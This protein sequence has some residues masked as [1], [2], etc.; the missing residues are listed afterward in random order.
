MNCEMVMHNHDL[1]RYIFAWL[2][3]K[4]TTC[5]SYYAGNQCNICHAPIKKQLFYWDHMKHYM[6]R[7]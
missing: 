1:R 4:C 2:A 3:T 7:K 5:A 6:T